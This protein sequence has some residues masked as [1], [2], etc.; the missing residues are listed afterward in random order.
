[1]FTRATGPVLAAAAAALLI[2]LLLP[3]GIA[4]LRRLGLVQVVRQQGPASH[5]V[6]AGTP[7]A[8]GLLFVPLACLAAWAVDPRDAALL[9]CIAVTL[10]HAALGLADDWLKV[11]RR[12][13]EGLKARHKLVGQVLLGLLLAGFALALR[14]EAAVLA[15]PF[16]RLR[17]VASPLAFVALVLIAL[18]GSTNGANF[19]DGAD[20]LLGST[21]LVALAAL[22]VLAWTQGYLG[23]AALP[24][25]LAGALLAFL[26]WNWYPARV[27][28]GDAGSM[29]I[30]AAFASVGVLV[31]LPLYLPLIGLL[32]CL[33][34]LSVIAQVAWFRRTG[35][36]LLRMSPLHHHLELSGWREGRLVP[37]L[38]LFAVACAAL[39]LI[40]F[41]A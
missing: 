10:G 5:L 8:A 29:A 3:A 14:P 30:G 4:M 32:F 1:M 41:W 37:R 21:G 39:G 17:L 13:P 33:E 24:L 40:A 12:R 36:R 28:M 25:A 16:S 31:G 2:A 35:R 11:V 19:T 15:V 22:G 6:K 23:M 34:V 18:L 9:V 27:F 26:R 7:T 20:G 38:L